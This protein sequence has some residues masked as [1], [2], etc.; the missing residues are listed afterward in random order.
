MAFSVRHLK[1]RHQIF[2]VSLP[3]L[4]VLL[5]SMALMLYAFWVA[6]YTRRS[7]A[8]AEESIVRGETV[9]RHL[10]E[11]YMGVRGYLLTGQPKLL[12]RY[13]EN[14]GR[15]PLDLDAWRDL[16]ADDPV[17]A[18]GVRQIREQVDR[19]Q[20]EWV[21]PTLEKAKRKEVLDLARTVQEGEERLESLRGL[22][23]NHLGEDEERRLARERQSS[24]MVRR[25][26]IV[27]LGITLLLGGALLFL[28]R[29]VARLIAEPVF[30]L[31]D[32][33]ERVSRGDFQVSLPPSAENEFGVLSRSFSRMTAALREER[34]EMAALSRFSEAVTQCTTEREVYEQLLHSFRERFQPR[35]V[36]IFNLNATE[37]YLEAV[38]TLAP[39][40]ENLRSWPVI[41]EPRSCKAV[42][43]GRPFAV[44]DVAREPLC[45]ANFAP[46]TEG[47]YYCGPLIAGGVIIGAVRLEGLEG[48]WSHERERLLESYFSG[49]ASALANLH[50]MDTMKRQANIDL[51]TG[52]YNRRFLEDYAR[53]L[54]AMARRKEQPLGVLMM[55]IDHFKNVNDLYGHDGGDRILRQFAKTV[56]SAMRETNLVARFGGEEFLVLLPDTASKACLAVA[57]RIRHAVERM[58]VGSTGDKPSVQVTVS[59][60][61]A[62]YP[63]HGRTFEELL[64]AADR[65]LYDSKHAGRNRATLYVEQV[66]PAG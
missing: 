33:S 9:L 22:I 40:P 35:Q 4:F 3:P 65:A 44:E 66:E 38:A 42:R 18:A 19:W 30:Q 20:D 16:E 41:D 5:C 64:Q 28:T 56:T 59:L 47:S 62:V 21:T 34:E 2:L 53:K 6:S 46:P 29:T 17:H 26:L 8:S 57:E 37:N 58:T 43:M 32:A 48:P 15:I 36:I 31:I 55:D 25:M 39:L 45:P 1:I 27:G 60:G 24:Q 49:A 13:H 7:T 52:L 54:I 51:V 50:S 23:L 14:L 12:D 63:D 61:I 10:T 11:T